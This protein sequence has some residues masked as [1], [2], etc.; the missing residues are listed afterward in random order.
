MA[1][2]SSLKVQDSIAGVSYP[3][4]KD[5][6]ISRA[7]ENNADQD[8]IQSLQSLEDTTFQSITEVTEALS[9]VEA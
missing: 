8:V 4:T 2:A 1:H 6:L 5:E 3:A 7:R 9:K